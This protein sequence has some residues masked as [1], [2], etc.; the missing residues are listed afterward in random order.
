LDVI[1]GDHVASDFFVGVLVAA[2]DDGG[3]VAIKQQQIFVFEFVAN[4][5]FFEGQIHGGVG[6]IEIVDKSHG[7]AF[8]F[9]QNNGYPSI[10]YRDFYPHL[11]YFIRYGNVLQSRQLNDE[12]GCHPWR[13]V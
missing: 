7:S 9:G 8:F 2:Y 11:P 5:V 6:H 10:V 4:G 1:G 3:T 13:P 12:C